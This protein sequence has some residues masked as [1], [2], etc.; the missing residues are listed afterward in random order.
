MMNIVVT[1]LLHYECYTIIV[2]VNIYMWRNGNDVNVVLRHAEEEECTFAPAIN[3]VS[4]R[5]LESSR[6]MPS[7][8]FKH[9]LL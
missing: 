5:L 2:Y 3:P 7:N 4:E 6:S 9:E 1:V 8:F